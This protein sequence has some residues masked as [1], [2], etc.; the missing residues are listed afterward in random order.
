MDVR[1][2]L[3]ARASAAMLLLCLLWSLQQVSLK[4]VADRAAPML[5]I[6]WRSCIA[7]LLVAALMAWR[8]ERLSRA[9]VGPGLAAGALFAFEYLLV[10]E[11]LRWTHASHVVVFLYTAPVFAALGLAWR[12]PAERLRPLQWAGVGIAF[13]GIAL[14]FLG[15]GG[16][17]A[18][19]DGK[20][21]LGDALALL[22]GMAWGATTVVIRLTRLSSA[23]A[24]ETLLYQLVVC[25]ALLLPAS[26]LL[27]P[28]RFTPDAE[29]WAHLAFQ[30]VV[31]T[32]ASFLLW[33]RLL[34]RYLASR[35]G[36][37]SFLTPVFGVVLGALLLGEPLDGGFLAG[38]ALVLAGLLL[39]SGHGWVA[40]RLARRRAR[41]C[42]DAA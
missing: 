34:R 6:G 16:G 36:M 41:F 25:A 18:A 22:A 39:V 7:A 40:G 14:A 19:F 37:F 11:A 35:L 12:L 13:A 32:F 27:G 9:H 26:A 8:G 20:V 2:P 29:V 4:L 3:D 28:S 10:A 30:G 15:R 42:G 23:P 33:F 17:A 38:G 31:V 1:R 24:T 21:L 5:M